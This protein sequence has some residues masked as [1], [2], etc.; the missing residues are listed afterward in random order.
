MPVARG[1]RQ[2]HDTVHQFFIYMNK[3]NSGESTFELIFMLFICLVSSLVS[4]GL[5]YAGG[6]KEVRIEAVKKGYAEWEVAENG[7][8]TFTWKELKE[9]KKEVQKQD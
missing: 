8:T 4:G 3:N 9:S 1:H 6:Q 2:G 7:Q 5:G